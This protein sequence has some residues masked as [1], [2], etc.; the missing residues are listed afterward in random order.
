MPETETDPAAHYLDVFEAARRQR[1]VEGR[2]PLAALARL[3]PSLAAAEGALEFRYDGGAD[4]RGRPVGRLSF[5]GTV[6]LVCD[7]CGGPLATA[8][9]GDARYYFVRSEAELARI[10]VDEAE[11]EPLLGSARFDLYA[12]VEDEAI[13]ALPISPRHAD[14]R[15]PYAAGDEAP[16]APGGSGEADGEAPRRRPFAALARLKPRQ[17]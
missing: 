2:L 12:L 9:A 14:C 6:A 16:A 15:P 10:P 5:A 3:R 8:L 4:A 7:R 13:L 11:E 17:Q 1:V